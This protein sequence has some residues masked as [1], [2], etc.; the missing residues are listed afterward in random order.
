M[1]PAPEVMFQSMF[2]KVLHEN[3]FMVRFVWERWIL[4]NPWR[5][6]TLKAPK[7]LTVIKLTLSNLAF[8]KLTWPWNAF[9]SKPNMPGIPLCRV[10]LEHLDRYTS[11]P[12]L[13]S[14]SPCRVF[15]GHCPLLFFPAMWSFENKE[16][17]LATSVFPPA[18]S[19]PLNDWPQRLT[20]AL[21]SQEAWTE[22]LERRAAMGISS[23]Y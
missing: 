2:L 21:R 3:G 6:S 1:P 19:L 15:Q 14:S 8:S 12:S 4:A 22:K 23:T 10:L 17:A 9:H 5:C 20:A 11:V 18:L 16:C 13:S 7:G